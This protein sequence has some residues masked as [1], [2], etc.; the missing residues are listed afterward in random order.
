MKRLVVLVAACFVLS[1][2]NTVRGF[3]QD[4]QKAGEKIED[5]AKKK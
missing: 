5:A 4:M 2:C 1:A 3:G